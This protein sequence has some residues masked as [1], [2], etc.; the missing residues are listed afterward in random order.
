MSTTTP[1][2]SSFGILHLPRHLQIR[3]RL[4]LHYPSVAPSLVVGLLLPVA[5]KL[6]AADNLADGEET[7]NLGRNNASRHPLCAGHAADLRE[8]VVGV[9][10]AETA[11]ERRR[12][13]ERAE[14]RL[15]V[16]LHCLDG[17][18]VRLVLS[19]TCRKLMEGLRRGHAALVDKELAN[20][21]GDARVVRDLGN[22]SCEQQLAH[23]SI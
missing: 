7:E 17:T 1:S 22:Q 12:L 20:L 9:G 15:H 11:D 4:R 5:D 18:E 2:N 6:E 21:E 14:R 10:V 8:H 13:A 16:R 3:L 19:L 23:C